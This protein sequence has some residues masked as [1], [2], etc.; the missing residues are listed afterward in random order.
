MTFQ[1]YRQHNIVCVSEC[2]CVQ[3][4][5]TGNVEIIILFSHGP[6]DHC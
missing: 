1:A 2:M 5:D 4:N 3:Y 6:N